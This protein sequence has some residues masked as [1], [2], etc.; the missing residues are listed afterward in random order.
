[1]SAER[2]KVGVAF[3]TYEP[4]I[5]RRNKVSEDSVAKVAEVVCETLNKAGVEATLIPLQRSMFNFLRRVKELDVDVIVN[6]CEG[7]FG[8]PQWE[9]N[10]AAV[11]EILHIPFTGNGSRPLALC[12]DKH[13][14]KAILSSYNLPVAPSQLITS[15][16]DMVDLR[17]P[18]IVKPNSEDASLGV[19]PESVVYDT[20]A[21]A[22]QVKRIIETYNQPAIVEEFIDGREFNVAILDDGEPKALPVSEID[23]SSMPEG[24]PKIC[25]YEAKWYP[26]HILYQTTPPICPARIDDELRERLQTLALNAFKVMGC[27]DYARVDLRMNESGEIF[28][29]EVNP[30]P[31]ISLDAGYARALKA[32]GI[33]YADF[34]KMMIANALRRKAQYA[35]TNGKN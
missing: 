15:A 28:I 26:D 12:Q 23:F 20:A 4:F 11:M 24:Y 5:Y 22:E 27:R 19:H 25:S 30:N 9:S 13:Q 14:A 32:A 34:W 7:F 31:D 6:L 1:M 21:L 33:D 17:F 18:V 8:K 29:L 35:S 10:V 2:L 16:E 3:N